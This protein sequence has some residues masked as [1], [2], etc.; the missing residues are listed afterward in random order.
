M[1]QI[2]R[3][4]ALELGFEIASQTPDDADGLSFPINS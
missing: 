2:D 1:G 3:G 4:E